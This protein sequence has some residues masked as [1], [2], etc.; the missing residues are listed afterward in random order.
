MTEKIDSN[1]ALRLSLEAV[2]YG[3][4]VLTSHSK[5]KLNG[6]IVNTVIQV[7]SNPIKIAVCVNKE[8][9]THSLISESGS[10][11][12]S[13][14]DE[15]TPVD[16]VRNFGFRS[17]RDADKFSH[18]QHKISSLGNPLVTENA[19][20]IIEA[21]V[22]KTVD[23]GSHFIFIG[24]VLDTEL[25]KHGKP[26]TYAH[27]KK[28]K[29]GKT[30]PN[31]PS[32]W[33]TAEKTETNSEVPDNSDKKFVCGVCGYVYDPKKG[34]PESNIPAN[35]SFDSLPEDWCC[36]VCNSNKKVFNPL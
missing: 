30:A 23:V 18:V 34:C 11:S 8:G 16:F 4:Y 6:S 20:A 14:L 5:N 10:F 15:S 1:D 27:Y 17:G 32:F 24:E 33:Q 29:K 26:L 25:L 19:I 3:L 9:L 2:S 31:A 35:T 36:P 13:V 21:K 22:F 7:S 28:V 12:V